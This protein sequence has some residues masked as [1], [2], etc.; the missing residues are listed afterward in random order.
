MKRYGTALVAAL[1]LSFSACA[2]EEPGGEEQGQAEQALKSPAAPAAPA[3][4]E[5]LACEP[6]PPSNWCSNRVGKAC[7]TEGT[8]SRCYIPNYCEW[9]LVQCQSG[10]WVLIDPS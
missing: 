4:G 3:A 1:L 2:A 10:S 6:G 8:I 5:Q 9:G 7:S